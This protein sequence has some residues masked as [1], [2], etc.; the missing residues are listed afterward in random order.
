VCD[1][2]YRVHVSHENDSVSIMVESGLNYKQTETGTHS[3][4]SVFGIGSGIT[5]V[6][7]EIIGSRLSTAWQA[8]IE[9]LH[10]PSTV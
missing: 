3:A 6:D 8:G 5:D 9:V 2:P 1:D 10:V 7:A 4:K